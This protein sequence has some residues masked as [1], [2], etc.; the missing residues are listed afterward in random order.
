M[1]PWIFAFSCFFSAP[2]GGVEF[3]VRSTCRIQAARGALEVLDEASRTPAA[4]LSLEAFCLHGKETLP[5]TDEQGETRMPQGFCLLAHRGSELYDPCLAWTHAPR[6]GEAGFPLRVLWGILLALAGTF[7]A[8]LAWRRRFR[9][10]KLE[11]PPVMPDEEAPEPEEIEIRPE[12]RTFIPWR[13][14]ALHGQVLVWESSLP[15]PGVRVIFTVRGQR[16]E[17]STDADGTFQVPPDAVDLRFEKEGFHPV[18]V[19]RPSGRVVVRL[20]SLPVRALWLL[21]QI[22]RRHDPARAARLSPRQA[23]D[24]RIPPP[25]VIARLEQ[26]A[27]GGVAPANGELE[28]MERDLDMPPS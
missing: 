4:G 1:M 3:V 16:Q 25:D 12:R 19:S 27:Y 11:K 8:I 9:R 18:D 21:R 7:L 13:R 28:R 2:D 20:M 6:Q 14:P 15:L 22:C 23:L 26:L 24:A 17:T 10:P 5:P